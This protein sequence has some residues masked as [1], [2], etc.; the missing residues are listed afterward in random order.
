MQARAVASFLRALHDVPLDGA[1]AH[2]VPD[3]ATTRGWRRD[4]IARFHT[5][6]L[7]RLPEAAR[8]R[9]AAALERLD[10][11]PPAVL[12]HGDLRDEHVLVDEHGAVTGIIDWSDA[13]AGDAAKD[14]AWLLRDRRVADTVTDA[15]GEDHS[16][17]A[18]DWDTV[19]PCYAV[20]HGFDTGDEDLVAQAVA[21][22]AAAGSRGS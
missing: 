6:V 13:R 15:Y 14:L 5:E 7:P 18:A 19:A 2:G 3:A 17:R 16:A 21:Q 1:V 12:V 20:T 4:A 10:D 22:L 11:A 9:V 8:A